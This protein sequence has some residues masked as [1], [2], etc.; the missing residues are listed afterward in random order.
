MRRVHP[1]RRVNGSML[2]FALEDQS[3]VVIEKMMVSFAGND[4]LAV[5]LFGVLETESISLTG[6]A[7][8]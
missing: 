8:C 6:A 4:R 2:H 3:V 5:A 1:S 7:T